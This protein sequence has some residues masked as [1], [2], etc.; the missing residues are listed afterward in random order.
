MRAAIGSCDDEYGALLNGN[1][2]GGLGS[3]HDP[4]TSLVPSQGKSKM[5]PLYAWSVGI[6]YSAT[7]HQFFINISNSRIYMKLK[8][9]TW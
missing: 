7:K 8:L 2:S 3:V 1:R 9:H 4:K 5:R 6:L